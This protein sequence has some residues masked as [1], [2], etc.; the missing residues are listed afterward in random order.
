MKVLI[1]ADGCPVITEAIEAAKEAGAPVL[2]VCDTAHVMQREGTETLTV[3]K[4]SD[5]ADFALVNRVRKGDVVVTQDY[6]LAA[7]V[8]AKKG[9]PIDQNGRIYTEDNIDLLLST[10]HEAKKFRQ[11]GGRTKGPKKRREEDDRRFT[12]ALRRLL[13]LK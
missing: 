8:L 13:G 9:V 7:M 1:D 2:L 5:A 4:G 11:A 6:G 3:S 12:A 10:R